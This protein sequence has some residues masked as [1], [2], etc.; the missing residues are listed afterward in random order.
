MNLWTVHEQFMNELRS[1][2]FIMQELLKFMNCSRTECSW[3]FLK[4]SWN[5]N[6]TFMTVH[7]KFINT[8]FT[9]IHEQFTNQVP[10]NSSFMNCIGIMNCLWTFMNVSFVFHELFENFHEHLVLEQFM[11][12]NSSWMKNISRTDCSWKFLRSSWN[13]NETFMTVHK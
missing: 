5:T 8:E 6:E 11:N 2:K 13:T 9:I 1:W 3:K 7:E 4:S 12:L 10:E